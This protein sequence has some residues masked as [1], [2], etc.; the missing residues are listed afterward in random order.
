[1]PVVTIISSA[2]LIGEVVTL[3]FILGAVF[4]LGGTYIGGIA[5]TEQLKRVFS[6]V[7]FR[8]KA[9]APDC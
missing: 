5:R 3:P 8:Q 7:H 9:P 4:V 1:M 6:G 2:L